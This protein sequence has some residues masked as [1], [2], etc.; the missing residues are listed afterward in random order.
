MKIGIV[1]FYSECNYGAFLQALGSYS[2]LKSKGHDVA[3]INYNPSK[4]VSLLLKLGIHDG[5]F[6]HKILR[7]YNINIRYRLK[8][9][10]EKYLCG[11]EEA[12]KRF[13]IET[14]KANDDNIKSIVE[15]FDCIYVGS[16][17]VWN[18]RK[19]GKEKLYYFLN[20]FKSGKTRKISY[21]ACFGQYYQNPILIPD[22]KEA[23][24]DFNAIS[25]RNEV[26]RRLVKELAGIGAPIVCDPT[27]LLGDYK[28]AESDFAIRNGLKDYILVYCLDP[29]QKKKH[30]KSLDFLRNK[31]GKKVVTITSSHHTA[32]TL[33]NA[34]INVYD[35][36]PMDWLSLFAN[37]SYVYTDSFHGA[38]FSLLYRKE[39][40]MM[41]ED[42]ERADR[43]KD[44][45][46]RYE[47]GNRLCYSLEDVKSKY[48]SC[49]EYENI[50]RRIA[51]HRTISMEYLTNALS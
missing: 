46:E 9:Y 23:L 51:E 39:L 38:I 2:Y 50:S 26:S 28:F 35:A 1:T 41:I 18:M 33:E 30:E 7:R 48:D 47:V 5:T 37:A 15:N 49:M 6:F 22:M 17:Q 36:T 11:F 25:V 43:L 13:F 31:L 12:R 10:C 16:D 29:R 3:F 21:A 8:P 27:V 19:A 44:L 14:E 4:D 24:K 45:S 42:N 34:D 32:W 20:F 40:V